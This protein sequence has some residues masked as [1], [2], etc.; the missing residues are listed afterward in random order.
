[1][2][3]ALLVEF[4]EAGQGQDLSKHGV[5][6]TKALNVGQSPTNG[7]AG[8]LAVR[9]ETMALNEELARL[10]V[11]IDPQTGLVTVRGA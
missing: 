2:L 3:G 1:M 4:A 11:V 7:P 8:R 9:A 5:R 10:G 6:P